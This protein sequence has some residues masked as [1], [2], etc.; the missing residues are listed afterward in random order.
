MCLAGSLE[1]SPLQ[2]HAVLRKASPP[3]AAFTHPLALV[4]HRHPALDDGAECVISRGFRR[5]L[6]QTPCL[7]KEEITLCFLSACEKSHGLLP[8]S[9]LSKCQSLLGCQQHLRLFFFVSRK[10]YPALGTV[11]THLLV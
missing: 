11:G 1:F 6:E 10:P 9:M 5:P 2:E 3:S 4:T 7:P 8:P